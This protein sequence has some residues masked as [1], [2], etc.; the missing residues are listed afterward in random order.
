MGPASL[1][2]D[3]RG[4]NMNGYWCG[5]GSKKMDDGS[6]IYALNHGKVEC[7]LLK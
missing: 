7:Q 3:V 1:Q 6:T 5:L 2:L 4:E